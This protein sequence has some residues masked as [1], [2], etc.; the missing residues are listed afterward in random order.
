M[1]CEAL[2]LCLMLA[3]CGRNMVQQ[4]R[5][6]AYERGGLFP[7]GMAMQAPPPGVVARDALIREAAARRPPMSRALVE[8]GRERYVIFCVPCHGHDGSGDGIVPAR[9][10]PHP[11]DFHSQRLRDAPD[12]HFYLVMTQGYGV[13]YSYADRVPA[14]DRWAIAAYIRSLQATGL[15]PAAAEGTKE[16]ADAHQ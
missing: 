14:R 5:Y 13:M 7:N 4:A 12:R 1:R 10:F 15:P 2:L 9:G 6:D 3:A 11:P 8:R 16:V